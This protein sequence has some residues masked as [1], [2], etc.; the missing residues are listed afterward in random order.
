VIGDHDQA[1]GGGNHGAVHLGLHQVRRGEAGRHVH[2]VHAEQQG[3]HVQA[4]DRLHRDG[5]D[6]CV[7]R[8]AHAAGE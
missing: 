2:P 5:A 8:S 4:A 6:Q 7:G 1:A 3:V